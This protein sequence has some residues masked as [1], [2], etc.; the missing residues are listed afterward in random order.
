MVV[1]VQCA[2][3]TDRAVEAQVMIM[4]IRLVQNLIVRAELQNTSDETAA[5]RKTA[6]YRNRDKRE[7]KEKKESSKL[8]LHLV[9]RGIRIDSAIVRIG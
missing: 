7:A 8:L 1:W 4:I 6:A 3:I 9:I 2:C 5:Y